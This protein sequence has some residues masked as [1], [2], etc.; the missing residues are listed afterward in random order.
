MSMALGW[1]NAMQH[2]V[3]RHDPTLQQSA[4]RLSRGSA[5]KRQKPEHLGTDWSNF[6]SGSSRDGYLAVIYTNVLSASRGTCTIDHEKLK[7]IHG[8]H[9]ILTDKVR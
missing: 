3:L 6:Y 2:Q 1:R 8:N 5:I 7:A 9:Y 4:L